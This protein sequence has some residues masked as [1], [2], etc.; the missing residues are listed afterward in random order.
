MAAITAT[1]PTAILAPAAT[2]ALE[3]EAAVLEAAEDEE[4]AVVSA[5]EVEV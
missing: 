1:M 4:S 5:I 2:S 3:L